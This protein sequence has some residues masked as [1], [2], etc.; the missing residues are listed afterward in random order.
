MCCVASTFAADMTITSSS[1]SRTASAVF[2]VS[3]N[4]LI[5]TLENTS[6]DDALVPV[7]ILTGVFFDVSGVSLSLVPSSAVVPIGSIVHNGTTDP[8]S[9]VGGEWAYRDSL[10]GAPG[11]T[12]YGISSSGLGLFGPGDLFPG[13]NLQGPA[14]P[15]GVQYGI[16]TAGD[17]LL[18]GNT[19]LTGGS[20]ALI[21]NSVMLTLT[22][23]PVGFDP[24]IQI[25]N[26]QFQYGTDLDEPHFP[27]PASAM[28]VGIAAVMVLRRRRC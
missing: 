1:G 8:G 17:N 3:G 11:N 22:G 23:L 4:D 6:P 21:K 25:Q 7:D 18:T 12:S 15:D 9:N 24:S 19:P 27:E 20:N 26:V 16:T 13:S 10:S 5:V 2:E 14:S 28:L